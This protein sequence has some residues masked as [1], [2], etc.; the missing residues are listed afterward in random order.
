MSRSLTRKPAVRGRKK[1][2]EEK[3]KRT[4]TQADIYAACWQTQ[5]T[6]KKRYGRLRALFVFQSL[7]QWF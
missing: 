2:E 1:K 4:R 3:K 7:N 6:L 5:K